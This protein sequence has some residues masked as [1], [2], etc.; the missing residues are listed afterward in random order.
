[1]SSLKTLRSRLIQAEMALHRLMI[2]EL[3]VH[4]SVGGYGSTTYSQT[5]IDKLNIY[6][7][8]IKSEIAA[9]Q[10]KHRRGPLLVK[11]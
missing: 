8:K 10:N 6:I 11:F 4:V 2:G 5:D 3:E 1:M 7:T 9:R